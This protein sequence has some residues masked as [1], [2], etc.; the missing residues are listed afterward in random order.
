MTNLSDVN[1]GRC[2]ES[3]K[4]YWLGSPEKEIPEPD[5]TRWAQVLS[6]V[7]KDGVE[8][9]VQWYLVLHQLFLR[10]EPEFLVFPHF[11]KVEGG[12]MLF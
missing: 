8:L 9:L 11:L 12:S 5:P 6:L 10:L 3:I 4:P 7:N 1:P 2:P